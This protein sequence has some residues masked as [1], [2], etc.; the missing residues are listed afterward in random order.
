MSA[1]DRLE[2]VWADNSSVNLREHGSVTRHCASGPTQHNKSGYPGLFWFAR[3][4]RWRVQITFNRKRVHLGYFKDIEAAA[5][6]YAEA[7]ARFH[8]AN[9]K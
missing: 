7:K 3:T 9:K 4:S 5:K 6:A 1:T 2:E 8:P